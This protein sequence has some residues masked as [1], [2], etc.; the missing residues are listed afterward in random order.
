MDE[1]RR[2]R[3]SYAVAA[4]AA[5]FVLFACTTPQSVKLSTARAAQLGLVLTFTHALV[6]SPTAIVDVT[7]GPNANTRLQLTGKQHLSVNGR[8]EDPSFPVSLACCVYRFTV[9]RPPA[10]GQYTIIYTDERGQQT[11]AVVPAPQPDLSITEPSAYTR[12]PIPKPGSPLDVHYTVP[13]FSS[14]VSS[15]A[16]PFMQIDA[17]AQGNCKHRT[18]DETTASG[19]CYSNIDSGQPNVTGSAVISDAGSPPEHGFDNTAPG[20]GE[21]Y[22]LASVAGNLPDTGFAYAHFQMS[23]LVSIPI[24][25]V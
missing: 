9:P 13:T 16:G 19:I 5:V 3:F 2:S 1:R 6:S 21:L 4:L 11:T 7:I 25:W 12:I 24:T 10:G 17:G 14:L 8:D 18:S 23:D 15:P 20:P 22:V